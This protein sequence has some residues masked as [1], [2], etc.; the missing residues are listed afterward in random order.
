[1]LIVVFALHSRAPQ[2][3]RPGLPWFVTVFAVLVAL[4][5]VS[6]IFLLLL[7]R[8]PDRT[9]GV[10]VHKKRRTQQP[11][12]GK[13]EPRR[14]CVNSFPASPPVLASYCY[15]DVYKVIN[16][17]VARLRGAAL[18]WC[19]WLLVCCCAYAVHV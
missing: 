2:G 5:I 12:E 1:M 14:L 11:A 15:N 19:A 9:A 16:G 8:A 3:V 18:C 10:V 4:N 7:L 13:V 6:C 17:W